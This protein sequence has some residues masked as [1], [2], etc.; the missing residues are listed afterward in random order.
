MAIPSPLN[1]ILIRHGQ[2]T[3]NRDGVAQGQ[4]DT[5]LTPEG[6]NSTLIKAGKVGN[7]AFDKMYSSD[8]KRAVETV[9]ILRG[10]LPG[11]PQVEYD[12]DLREIDFGD[13]SGKPKEEIMPQILLHKA[14]PGLR[15]PGGECGDDLWR[16]ATRFFNKLANGG[17]SGPALVVTHYGIMETAARI[18]NL[19]LPD[20]PVHVGDEDV[21]KITLHGNFS[22]R[23]EVL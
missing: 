11:L 7:M 9:E 14:Y 6:V 15:Y 16:R 13:L 22:A 8:L 5:P 17:S 2:T 18:F 3:G 21:W 23:L 12:P 4:T 10:V 1:V 20:A 19:V